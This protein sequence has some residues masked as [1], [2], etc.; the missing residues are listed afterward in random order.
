I[1]VKNYPLTEKYCKEKLTLLNEAI[2][3]LQESLGEVD[4]TFKE[5]ET[6]RKMRKFS[7]KK[8]DMAIWL[9]LET[10]EFLRS[11]IQPKP[12]DK[13]TPLEELADVLI[14]AFDACNLYGIGNWKEVK[15]IIDAKMKKNYKKKY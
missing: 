12:D 5:I 15:K 10:V 14:L 3:K 4:Q 2:S 6:Y 1:V 11:I 7:E 9:N 13:D 8:S